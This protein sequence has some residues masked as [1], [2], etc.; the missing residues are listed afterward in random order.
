MSPYAPPA[1]WE[2]LVEKDGLRFIH[3]AAD[4]HDWRF[5]DARSDRLWHE[6]AAARQAKSA[7]E[8]IDD[9]RDLRAALA[10]SGPD[11]WKRFDLLCHATRRAVELRQQAR[12]SQAAAERA[13][14]HE[15]SS[16]GSAA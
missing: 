10:G 4:K 8:L 9:A 15:A 13:A 7:A 3:D 16:V 2:Y 1:R 11:W 14:R 6:E 12:M 5:A